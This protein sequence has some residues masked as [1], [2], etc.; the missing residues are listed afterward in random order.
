VIV[1]LLRIDSR[2]IHGQVAM[3]WIKE[4]G[5]ETII[6]AGDSVAQDDL[7][8]GLLLQ[9]APS[10]IKTNVLTIAKAARVAANAKYAD[11]PVLFIVESPAD[12]LALIEEGLPVN[13]VN[14]GGLTFKTGATQLSDA[15]FVLPKDVVALKHLDDKGIPVTIQTLPGNHKVDAFA[16]MKS[17]GL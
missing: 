11:M 4:V 15:V 14:L 17:K 12:A 7:R 16:A 1:K 6:C 3:N 2:L 9:A 8:K 10:H 5:A 13:E